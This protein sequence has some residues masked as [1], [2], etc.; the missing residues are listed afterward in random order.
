MKG[1]IMAGG[2]GSRLWPLTS[3]TSKQLL[4]VFDKPLIYYPLS[5]LM[6]SKIN[7]LLVISTVTDIPIIKSLLG[8]GTRFGISIEYCV[9]DSPMG[10][11]QGIILAKDFIGKDDFALILGDNIFYGQ[12]LNNQLQFING[13]SGALVFAYTVNDATRY[14]VV[15]LDQDLIPISIEEKPSK[16]KSNFAL[17][18]LYF[19]DNNA[20]NIACNLK[21]SARGEL[22]I[23]DVLNSYLKANLLSVIVMPVGTAWLDAGTPQS[24]HDA[25][26][27]VRIVEERQG[28]KI[29]C[30]EEIA[31]NNKWIG[32]EF[33]LEVIKI[34]PNSDYSR[35]LKQI[36][37]VK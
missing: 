30:P 31:F 10:I 37:N 15:E 34:N 11:A 17:T 32:E 27:F 22:E 20:V 3:V 16:P 35:Y 5:T 23:T 2:S 12:E 8:D 13:V 18:G 28:V 36:I 33:L 14:G 21:P 26:T 19:F 24:L 29:A 1:I 9:Q 4:P 6:S 25:G 7:E